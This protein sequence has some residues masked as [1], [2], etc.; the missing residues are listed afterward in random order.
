MADISNAAI[1]IAMTPCRV[2][3]T[4]N[5]AGTYG[6]P[7]LT[8]GTARTWDIDASPCTGIPTGG[9]AA[10]ALNL[11]VVAPVASGYIA[12]YPAGSAMPGSA[13]ISWES[14]GT[15]RSND[16]IIPGNSSGITVF[17]GATTHLVIDI[18]GYYVDGSG[19]ISMNTGRHM[20]L[21]GSN[22]TE[23]FFAWNKDNTTTSTFG[24]SVHGY[25]NGGAANV[26]AL[27]GEVSAATG[28]ALAILGK[29][30]S[31]T[32]KSTAILGIGGNVGWTD[33]GN[34]AV[35]GVRGRADGG[36]YN[37]G[38]FGE[39]TGGGMQGYRVDAAGVL[40]TRGVVGGSGSDGL[41]TPNNLTA[42]G[43]K[44]FL[45]PHPTDAGKVIRYI[46]LEG[47]EAGTYFRGRGRIRGGYAIIDVPEDF[48]MVSDEE[49]LTVQV[50]PIGQTANVAVMDMNLDRITIKASRDVEFFYTVNGVRNAF[51]AVP[52]FEADHSYFIPEGPNDRIDGK[53]F[54]DVLKQRLIDN[55]TYNADGSVN[56]RT[57]VAMGWVAIWEAKEAERQQYI[58]TYVPRDP[59]AEE[60]PN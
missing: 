39:G 49:G 35:V 56:M 19:G 41:W 6:G 46:A 29:H 12:V 38:V 33:S 40:Q 3:D 36:A 58:Q 22:A 30:A 28:T 18:N 54:N 7:I 44:A 17:P 8:A 37:V 21:Y 1:F 43:V 50:T 9:V 42:T 20:W 2:A 31:V 45:E 59:L 51:P 53:V 10:F 25:R 15:I 60:P 32:D 11:T 4:R 52:V 26:P 14:A 23:F 57:A 16:A 48:R 27:R 13:T 34:T 24:A 55:G 47:G 5:A